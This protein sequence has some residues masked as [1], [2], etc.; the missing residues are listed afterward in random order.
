MPQHTAEE[1]AAAAQGQR[2]VAADP[3]EQALALA[4]RNRG[5]A[6][7][8][9]QDPIPGEGGGGEEL[10]GA[11]EGGGDEL[12]EDPG[13]LS[14]IMDSIKGLFGGGEEAA[15]PGPEPSTALSVALEKMRLGLPLTPEEQAAMG[16]AGGQG[17]GPGAGPIGGGGGPVGP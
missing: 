12:G 3:F 1:L 8:P 14:G 7:P 5:I 16:A 4:G 13:L 2:S 15:P 9:G 6:P 11:A 10:L 17:G